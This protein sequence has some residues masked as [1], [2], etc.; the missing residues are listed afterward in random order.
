ML[1]SN[2]V[3]RLIA[4]F[5]SSLLELLRVFPATANAVMVIELVA[6]LFGITGISHAVMDKTVAERKLASVV[7]VLAGLI[8][9]AQFIPQLQPLVPFLQHLA[10]IIGGGAMVAEV[11]K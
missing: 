5:L 9:I 4:A 1:D 8:A 2:G 10:A 7:A 3:K 6:G 11:V